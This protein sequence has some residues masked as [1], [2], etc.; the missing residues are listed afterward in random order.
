MYNRELLMCKPDFFRIAYQINPYMDLS[1]QPDHDLLM[2]EYDAIVAA[3]IAAGRTV[4]FM[5]PVENLPDMTY[6]ANQALIRGK[7]A[8]L[9]N[10]PKERAGE[11]DLPY[12]SYRAGFRLVPCTE[13]FALQ[14]YERRL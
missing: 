3:H 9:A 12:T 13:L 14:Q 4:Q 8:V 1:K 11:L 10:L 5:D 2:Q 6:T 7:K